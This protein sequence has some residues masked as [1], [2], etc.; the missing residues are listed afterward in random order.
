[1]HHI[2]GAGPPLDRL[3]ETTVKKLTFV[4]LLPFA[5]QA[6]RALYARL[7]T[8]FSLKGFTVSC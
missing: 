1:M 2:R 6:K 4:V 3:G 7:A 8:A 5:P